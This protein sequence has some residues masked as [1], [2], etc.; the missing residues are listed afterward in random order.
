MISIRPFHEY[1]VDVLHQYYAPEMSE[2]EILDMIHDW[3]TGSYKGKLFEMFAVLNDQEVVGL[4]SLYEHSSSVAGIGPQIFVDKR[5]QGYAAEAMRLMEAY[6]RKKGYRILKQQVSTE[7][8]PSIAL[9]GSLGYE[10]DM[11]V[12]KNQ[13]GGDVILYLKAL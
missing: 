3:E 2:S 6:A 11:Y 13:K 12:Y 4:I 10:T 1:D 9:H 5:R 8:L 7:N